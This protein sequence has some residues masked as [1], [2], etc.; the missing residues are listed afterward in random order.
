MGSGL[1]ARA[2][3]QTNMKLE[4]FLKVIHSEPEH[5]G[6]GYTHVVASMN[7]VTP[8]EAP[9]YHSPYSGPRGRYP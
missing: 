7:R 9:K 6:C 2:Y 5:F 4:C 3:P 1:E 8:I